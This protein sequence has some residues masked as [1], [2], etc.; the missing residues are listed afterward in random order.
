MII[1]LIPLKTSPKPLIDAVDVRTI[2]QNIEEIV[3]LSKGVMEEIR[4]AQ[5]RCGAAAV[6]VAA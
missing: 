2:F 6:S 4:K 3:R 5:V 1:F